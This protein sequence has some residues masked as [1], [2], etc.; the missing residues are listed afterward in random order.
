[1][2]RN[3]KV[4][5]FEEIA[6]IA[7]DGKTSNLASPKRRLDQKRASI[8]KQKTQTVAENLETLMVDCSMP[9]NRGIYMNKIHEHQV[10]GLF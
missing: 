2:Q 8:H 4:P 6:K 9:E 10:Q 5:E 7:I 1:M 3:A